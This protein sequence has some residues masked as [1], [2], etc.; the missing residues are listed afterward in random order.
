V[1]VIKTSASK[2]VQAIATTRLSSIF[3]T[4][5][6]MFKN[7]IVASDRTGWLHNP[8]NTARVYAYLK[9]QNMTCTQIALIGECCKPKTVGQFFEIAPNCNIPMSIIQQPQTMIRCNLGVGLID[10]ALIELADINNE[11][12]AN[13]CHSRGYLGR[14]KNKYRDFYSKHFKGRLDIHYMFMEIIQLRSLNTTSF[15]STVYAYI[16]SHTL[17]Y[18]VIDTIVTAMVQPMHVCDET[19]IGLKALHACEFFDIRP[20][21]I[22]DIMSPDHTINAYSFIVIGGKKSCMVRRK[23]MLLIRLAL[24]FT[25]PFMY[26]D[27]MKPLVLEFPWLGV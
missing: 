21:Y 2:A 14:E 6:N 1:V 20:R 3:Q 7:S 8:D 27:K 4:S 19:E 13:F 26:D 23:D 24:M 16:L 15:V 12:C 17:D 5:K 11:V 10:I 9:S 18:D 22:G 25:P